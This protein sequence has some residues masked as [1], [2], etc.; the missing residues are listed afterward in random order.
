MPI[1]P[2]CPHCGSD[3]TLR[4]HRRFLEKLVVV[5]RPYRCNLCDQRFL[6]LRSQIKENS[7]SS[8]ANG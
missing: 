4:S 7:V 6:V 3:E 1:P 8:S 5:A 2:K